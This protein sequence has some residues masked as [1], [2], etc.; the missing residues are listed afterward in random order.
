MRV[1]VVSTNI[2]FSY[3][4]CNQLS[5]KAG[6]DVY[7]SF[8]FT[9]WSSIFNPATNS[10]F[11]DL[12]TIFELHPIPL[13]NLQSIDAHFMYSIKLLYQ[14]TDLSELI[15]HDVSENNIYTHQAYFIAGLGT[16][17]LIKSG[18]KDFERIVLFCMLGIVHD[19]ELPS[20][21]TDESR[22]YEVLSSG[23][24]DN[25]P[26]ISAILHHGE[27]VLK[28]IPFFNHLPESFL[29]S[30]I[31][32]HERPGGNGFSKG[33]SCSDFDFF[34]ACFIFSHEVY[35]QYRVFQTENRSK[36]LEFCQKFEFNHEGIEVF[37]R[38]KN[39]FLKSDLFKKSV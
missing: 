39:A 11:I 15:N 8:S 29:E 14:Y 21:F 20:T 26:D 36:K 38:C 24:L 34:S 4:I 17:I 10:L 13:S 33:K 6:Y 3:L 9:H 12:K 35:D 19:F 27:N 30:I 37:I 5:A 28:T 22:F 2:N 1:L 7:E 32:H 23:A 16:D 18:Y 31:N 25:S